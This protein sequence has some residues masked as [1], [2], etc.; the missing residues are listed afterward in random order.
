LAARTATE[1]AV[2]GSTR[3]VTAPNGIRFDLEARR[4]GYPPAPRGEEMR[5]G[6]TPYTLAL[7]VDLVRWLRWKA[8]DGAYIVDVIELDS[9]GFPRA[10][11]SVAVATAVAAVRTMDGLAGS[12]I[13]DGAEGLMRDFRDNR[14]TKP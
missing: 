13:A 14:D 6:G 10:R 5:G 9:R 4:K 12:I 1:T 3:T 7:I 11:L 2:S 8:S